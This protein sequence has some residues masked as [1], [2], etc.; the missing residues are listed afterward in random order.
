MLNREPEI[1]ASLYALTDK[2]D[3]GEVYA[4]TSVDVSEEDY[5]GDVLARLEPKC[6]EMVGDRYPRLI[7]GSARSES[8]DLTQATYAC[9]RT[10]DHGRIQWTWPMKDV[11]DFI[12]AQSKPYPGAYAHYSGR[13]MTIWRA[14]PFG[15]A[16]YG[17]PG[18][19]ARVSRDGVH[20]VCGDHQA[21]VLERIQLQG[22]PEAD[23]QQIIQ[24]A[25]PMLLE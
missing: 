3:C 2:V 20:I 24:I 10:P 1:G 9:R 22:E 7:E 8:Q 19:I 23:A 11:Y 12:R 4:R 15:T 6:A 17:T 16:W 13:R 25:G 21:I 5:I 18:Q 14:R